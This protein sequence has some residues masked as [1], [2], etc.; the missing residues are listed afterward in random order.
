MALFLEFDGHSKIAIRDFRKNPSPVVGDALVEKAL[1]LVLPDGRAL[2]GFEAYRYVVLRVPGL[3]WQIPFFYM[4]VLSR[5]IGHPIYN[6]IAANRGRL[7]SMMRLGLRA[8][9]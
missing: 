6:W 3:W 5:L 8:R 4:P 1:Y 7:S 2:P 9:Y